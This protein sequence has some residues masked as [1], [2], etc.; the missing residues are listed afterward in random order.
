M[1]FVARWARELSCQETAESFHTSWDKVRDA[2][3][4]VV[5]RGL[6]H[7]VP[8]SIRANRRGRNPVRQGPPVPDL[9]LPARS[10]RGSPGC[11]GW[12]RSAPSPPSKAPLLCRLFGHVAALPGRDS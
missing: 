11:S 3:E 10:T 6:D 4:H 9:G 1:L 12:V 7:R 5:H 8:A 2:V